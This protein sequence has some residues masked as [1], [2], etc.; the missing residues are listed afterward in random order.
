M[1]CAQAHE[2]SIRA[3]SFSILLKHQVF[4]KTVIVLRNSLVGFPFMLA[5]IIISRERLSARRMPT[6]VTDSIVSLSPVSVITANFIE[7][8]VAILAIRR[9]FRCRRA[10]GAV[11]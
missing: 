10:E 2:S 3:A 5:S 1:T 11:W 8:T 4:V 6:S 7:V 9:A